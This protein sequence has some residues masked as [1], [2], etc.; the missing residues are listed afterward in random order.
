MH[1]FLD[2][3]R[4]VEALLSAASFRR[5]LPLRSAPRT[6]AHG[7][8][9]AISR[10]VGAR[11]AAVAQALGARLGWRVY[12]HELLDRIAQEMNVEVAALKSL[13]EQGTNW[14]QD[15]LESLGGAP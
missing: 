13:D 15:S 2:S 1:P 11:G 7:P 8:T 9:I 10:Q 5:T 3:N 12:D 4:S 14:L 6:W